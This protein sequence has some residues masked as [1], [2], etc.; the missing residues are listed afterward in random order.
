MP[1]GA[2]AEAMS[3]IIRLPRSVI[4]ATV[5]INVLGLALPL[6]ILQVYDRILANQSLGTLLWLMIALCVV[7]LL[8]AILKILRFYLMAWSATKAAFASEA[9]AVE[10]ILSAPASDIGGDNPTSWMNRFDSLEQYNNFK[11]GQSL[12]VLIDLPFLAIYLAIIL[13][14]AGPLVLPVIAVV[15]CFTIFV[16]IKAAAMRQ[17]LLKR[18]EHDQRRYDFIVEALTGVEAIKSMAMEPQMQRRLERLQAS[19]A[20]IMFERNLLGNQFTT[21]MS[22]MT[23]VILIVVVS[24]GALMVI[25]GGLSICALACTTMLTSRLVQPIMRFIPACLE[26]ESARIA[27]ERTDRL[28][29]IGN[30]TPYWSAGSHAQSRSRAEFRSKVFAFRIREWTSRS[31]RSTVSM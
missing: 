21:I 28:F 26:L 5:M 17:I 9:A 13:L 1:H 6:T 4:I 22:L 3:N 31:F 11:S 2:L 15:A 12:L 16:M 8:E 18:V 30:A 27:K 25:D 19:S 23:N 7:I 20:D 24:S 29:Q 14:V 10:R